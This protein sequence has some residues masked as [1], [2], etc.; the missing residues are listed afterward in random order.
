VKR[1][2]HRHRRLLRTRRERPRG[3]AA[4][5]RDELAL[6]TKSCE[7]KHLRCLGGTKCRYDTISIFLA[8]SGTP[9]PANSTS[10]RRNVEPLVAVVAR[11]RGPPL[12]LC[13][14]VTLKI[15]S[16][17]VGGIAMTVSPTCVVEFVD[18]EITRMTWSATGKPDMRRGIKLARHAYRSRAGSEP[19]AIKGMHFESEGVRLLPLTPEEIAEAMR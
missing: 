19:P 9:P 4:D 15:F 7:F 1:S 3:R 2:D 13:V 18:G 5:Q 12:P 8:V 16:L 14:I 11:A 10:R 17:T 6:V